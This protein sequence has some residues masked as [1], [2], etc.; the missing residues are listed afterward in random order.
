MSVILS[1]P[2]VQS[3]T[4]TWAP[5]SPARSVWVAQESTLVVDPQVPLEDLGEVIQDALADLSAAAEL[6]PALGGAK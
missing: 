2:P 6:R 1:E 5:I 3:F 4:V